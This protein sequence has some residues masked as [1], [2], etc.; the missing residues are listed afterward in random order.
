VRCRNELQTV[1]G[2]DTPAYQPY[3]S[4]AVYA[5]SQ[6]QFLTAKSLST[7]PSDSSTRMR[8]LKQA[9]KTIDVIVEA[10]DKEVG[11]LTDLMPSVYDAFD[12]LQEARHVE[13][14]DIS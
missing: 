3:Q 13:A 9:A 4:H 11:I 12:F 10:M 1:A 7:R 14:R 8:A 5:A 6:R 2:K